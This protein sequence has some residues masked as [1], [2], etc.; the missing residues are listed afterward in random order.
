MQSTN[1]ILGQIQQIATSV[2]SLIASQQSGEA[3]TASFQQQLKSSQ[4]SLISELNST[5]GA[6]YIFSGTKTD[7][8]PV[9]TP[10]P[11]PAEIG[12][13][14]TSYYQGSAQDTTTR[15]SE[16]QTIDNSVRAD[17]PAFQQLFA[18]IAQALSATSS[19][20]TGALQSA[21]TL[22][23]NGVQG[24]IALQA[25]VNANIVNVQQV[26][27]Q[28]QSLQTYYQGITDSISQSDV[29][30]LSTKVAQDQSVLEASFSTF[31]RISSLTLANYLK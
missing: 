29:V 19:S 3:S 23:Q 26:D 16:S 13:P 22:V 24:V 15:I 31:A 30:S 5:Y 18:G 9:K 1:T 20:G 8:A 21:E 28:S 7:V 27:T 4:S 17:N 2:Q 11:T 25:T 10:L 14:D 12:T 6:N